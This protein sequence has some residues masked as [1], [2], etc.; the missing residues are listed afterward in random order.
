M[1]PALGFGAQIPPDWKVCVCLL[2]LSSSLCWCVCVRPRHRYM[3]AGER[4]REREGLLYA[5]N[6][7][8]T[9]TDKTVSIIH[10]YSHDY[11]TVHPS[12]LPWHW[13]DEKDKGEGER[14][15]RGRRWEGESVGEMDRTETEPYFSGLCMKFIL[16]FV[17]SQ[18]SHEFAINFN[19]TNPFCSGEVLCRLVTRH[20]RPCCSL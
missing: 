19:P 16:T 20:P 15:N 5:N 2:L 6:Y 17:S 7:T 14:L 9:Y 4:E 1:F 3:Y 11:A 13:A 8:H 18:V 10:V 12:V